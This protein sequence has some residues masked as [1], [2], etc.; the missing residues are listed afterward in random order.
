MRFP[1]LC[2]DVTYLVFAVNVG[3]AEDLGVLKELAR[4]FLRFDKYPRV[5]GRGWDERS[6]WGML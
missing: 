3:I 1:R 4:A 6:D 5:V 2:R